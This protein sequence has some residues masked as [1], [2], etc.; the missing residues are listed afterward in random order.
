[1]NEK[2]LDVKLAEFNLS[3]NTLRVREA[4]VELQEGTKAINAKAV[5]QIESLKA[6]YEAAL[7]DLKEA[8]IHLLDAKEKQEKNFD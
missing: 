5:R 2:D 7:I 6:S 3:H 1:M 4:F 8:E